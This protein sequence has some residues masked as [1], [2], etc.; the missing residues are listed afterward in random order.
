VTQGG[1]IVEAGVEVGQGQL[2]RHRGIGRQQAVERQ[3]LVGRPQRIALDHLVGGLAGQPGPLDQ[4][5]QHAARRVEPEPALDVLA[6]SLRPDHQPLDQARRPD[7]HVVE[8]D[9]RVGQDHPLGGAVADVA[10]VPH[11]WFS[12]AGCA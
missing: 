3:A 11:G 8:Q 9:R 7:Q 12:R 10:L 6:H 4:R 2:L 1:R 5:Q